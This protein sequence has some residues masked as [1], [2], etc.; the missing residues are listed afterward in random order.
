[1]PS[2]SWD[3]QQEGTGNQGGRVSPSPGACGLVGAQRTVC[4]GEDRRRGA[5]AGRV[6]CSCSELQSGLDRSQAKDL[7]QTS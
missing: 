1:M 3:I 4:R 7:K 5:W 6:E 2:G